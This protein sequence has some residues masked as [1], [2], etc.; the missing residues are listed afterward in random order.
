MKQCT[1]WQKKGRAATVNVSIVA[2]LT[3]K[4]PN[5]D[6]KMLSAGSVTKQGTWI[7]F[8]KVRSSPVAINQLSIDVVSVQ[9]SPPEETQEYSLFNI[10]DTKGVKD[11]TDPLYVSVNL[12]G[13]QV[14]M[15]WVSSFHYARI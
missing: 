6:L 4:H 1:E 10:Q 9:L 14:A 2:E 12:N 13:K 11:K 7:K 8:A 15:D 3:T 5:V